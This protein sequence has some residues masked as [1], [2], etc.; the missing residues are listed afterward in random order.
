MMQ[1][2]PR[3]STRRLALLL[4]L[5]AAV[6]K[7]LGFAREILMAHVLGATMAADGFRSAVTATLLP[8][9]FLQN[10]SVPAVLV[11][12][13]RQ[14]QEHG[15]PAEMLTAL[16]GVLTLVTLVIVGVIELLGRT[17]I[18]MVVGGFS[19][20]AIALTVA[21]VRIM[22]LSLPAAVLVNC[23]A[24]GEIAVGKS[25]LTNIRASILNLSVM[26]G[27][28]AFVIWGNILAL[29]WAF[30][31]AFFVLAI[32]GFVALGR[33]GML[34]AS[35]LRPSCMYRT[36]RQF[37]HRL[38][39]LLPLPLAEQGNIWIE[40]LL[41]SGIV[42][43]AVASLDYARLLSETALLIISQPAGLAVLASDRSVAA[44]AQFDLIV[45]AVIAVMIPGSVFV[46]FFAPDVVHLVYFR[47]AFS[48]QAVALTSS[49]LQGI[50]FGLWAST[51]AWILL[52]ILNREG[53]NARA[54]M[55]VIAAYLVNAGF[56]LLAFSLGAGRLSGLLILG[57]GESIRGLV[58]LAGTC[59]NL[60]ERHR[61]LRSL[62]LGIPSGVLMGVLAAGI[63]A[64]MA[65]EL[66][67]L[68]A[69]CLACVVSCGLSVVILL[70]PVRRWMGVERFRLGGKA[71]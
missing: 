31:G 40:R 39:P 54:A 53:R 25:R 32:Y 49:P 58:L 57:L 50:S 38:A 66:P 70:S 55:I 33:D 24:A 4:M 43:G 41:A 44:S 13:N 26:L 18:D 52:R 69:G 20:A 23:F 16:A 71:T 7:G 28:G 51:L 64:S 35:G 42:T 14:A 9:A 62:A 19:E 65:G 36:G 3:S 8:A 61:I 48:A 67:R 59:L 15:N 27:L 37:F 1:A 12:M 22:A 17:W 10:E 29:A 47:G 21:F 6:S 11:P 34:D 56:N 45:R 63:G 46:F 60:P 5:G 30:T 2:V 68:A